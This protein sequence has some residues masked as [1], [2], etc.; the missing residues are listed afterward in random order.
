MKDTTGGRKISHECTNGD[1]NEGHEL[2]KEERPRMHELKTNGFNIS[3]F[4]RPPF[5]HSW[6]LFFSIN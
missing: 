4:I 1:T 3:I 6:Q 2:R 5:V